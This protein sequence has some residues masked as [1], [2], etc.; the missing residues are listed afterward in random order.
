[1]NREGRQNMELTGMNFRTR[2]SSYLY[3]K[4]ETVFCCLS[5]QV[6]VNHCGPQSIMYGPDCSQQYVG[7]WLRVA[8]IQC[9]PQSVTIT[10]TITTWSLHELQ[11]SVRACQ[12]PLRS[13]VNHCGPQSIT[14]VG[15]LL[16]ARSPTATCT[17]PVRSAVSICNSSP[18][19][20]E[21][22]AAGSSA[23]RS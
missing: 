13:A 23:V 9:G 19:A 20:T 8:L 18:G 16:P 6:A 12:N 3:E 17:D 14:G 10:A 22:V 15:K 11:L 5:L 1:M 7:L 2:N 21:I 4:S